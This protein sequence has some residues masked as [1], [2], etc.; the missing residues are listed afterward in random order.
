MTCSGRK[1]LGLKFLAIGLSFALALPGFASELKSA[2]IYPTGKITIYSGDQR[3]GEFSKEAP[4]PEGFLIA[5]DGKCGVKME[6]IY[7]V[8][9]DRSLFSVATSANP[10]KLLVKEG[11]VYFAI[12]KMSH[13]LSFITPSGSVAVLDILLNA[14]T[15]SSPLKGYVSVKQN[16]SE[17]GIIK[18]GSMIVS[19]QQGEM[20]IE[21][22]QRIIL[23][24]ADMDVGAPEE[25]EKSDEEEGKAQEATEGEK[26]AKEKKAGMSKNTKIVLGAVGGAVVIGGIGA[27]AAGG[28][29]GGGSGGNG[30][31]DG[32]DSASPSSPTP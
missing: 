3:V 27:L 30:G 4:F 7:L 2:R 24:Q 21:S 29:G 17:L 25:L 18:G 10:R 32:D 9:E 28:G 11:T 1:K 6:H 5:A 15:V 13:P 31:D 8:A 26:A 12:S 19:T 16:R 23:A 14:A 20:M 22:G